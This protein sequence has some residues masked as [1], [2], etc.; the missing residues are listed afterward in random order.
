MKAVIFD[1][2]GVLIDSEPLYHHVEMKIFKDL[3]LVISDEEYFSF[4]GNSSYY[5]WNKL[6]EKYNLSQEVDVL[7]ENLRK[8]YYT[9]LI[10]IGDKL[11]PIEGV[12]EL[13]EKLKASN[14]KMAV[15]SSSPMEVI[16]AVMNLFHLNE[17]F[18]VLVTGDMVPESKPSP[19]I[20]LLAAKKL[21]VEPS[22]CLVIED[23]Y[24]GV[25]AAKAANMSC[26][27][28]MN[29]NSGKQDLSAA[30][31]VVNSLKEILNINVI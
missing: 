23:S 26:I 12:I 11:Q 10:S 17:Y 25:M 16:E 6:K 28:Y 15:A 21:G 3:N 1:M 27:G 30:D 13:L 5:M 14:I 31:L 24:N 22:S 4:T 8:S 9:Y 7:A 29:L 20:F 2:D 19:D 18:S